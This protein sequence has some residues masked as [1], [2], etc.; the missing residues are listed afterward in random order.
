M[1]AHRQDA[2][3]NVLTTDADDITAPLP[4]IQA[5]RERESRL[6]ADRMVRL[7]GGNLGLGPGVMTVR[8]RDLNANAPRRIT[9]DQLPGF[10]PTDEMPEGSQANCARRAPAS[11]RAARGRNPAATRPAA[12]RHTG[13]GIFRACRGARQVFRQ[14]GCRSLRPV[15]FGE[16]GR[17]RA[18][19]AAQCWRRWR[20]ARRRAPLV[21]IHEFGLPG[22]PGRGMRAVPRR[23]K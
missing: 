9:V 7:E 17:H 19:L 1:L 23:R 12:D 18:R 20:P 16:G 2:V 21:C 8:L 14:S 22:M 4:G 13:R 3:A 15:I 11:C 10:A 6:R 5:E